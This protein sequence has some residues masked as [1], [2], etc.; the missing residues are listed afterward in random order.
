MKD[1]MP[2]G[3][4]QS[5]S[6]SDL[7]TAAATKT[8]AETGLTAGFS[9]ISDD[10]PEKS[11]AFIDSLNSVLEAAIMQDGALG[12]PD[13]GGNALPLAELAAA[14][15]P[16][17]SLPQTAVEQTQ[18]D[19]LLLSGLPLGTPQA[20]A[21]PVAMSADAAA[22]TD[23]AKLVT[24]TVSQSADT[25]GVDKTLAVDKNLAV[26]S[27]PRT[28][29]PAVTVQTTQTMNKAE[30]PA[31]T[32]LPL[33]RTL[34]AALNPEQ[35]ADATGRG[36]TAKA[37]LMQPISFAE[38]ADGQPASNIDALL[39]ETDRLFTS[40]MQS[41]AV[42]QPTELAAQKLPVEALLNTTPAA[43]TDALQASL[44]RS[45][46]VQAGGSAESVASNGQTAITETFGKADWGQGMGKQIL[47]M[48]NQNISRAEI[49]LN[50]AN[51]GPLEVRIDMDNDQVNVAFTSR[52]ADVREAV[53]LAL[54]RLREMLGDKGLNLADANI[55]Q[56]SFAEQH[57]NAFGQSD[58]DNSGLA[59]GISFGTGDDGLSTDTDTAAKHNTVTQA[60]SESLVDYYI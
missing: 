18:A 56:H 46:M 8:G 40:R 15:I 26:D 29:E 19:T 36:R 24:K 53:E 30:T 43:S 17:E 34:V 38:T 42:N 12:G 5:H 54:P 11:A 44:A 23:P 37:G 22:V 39:S 35:N 58:Q 59:S 27:R 10:L 57:H 14:S 60:L 13:A 7:K 31:L 55:S 47:W 52:H 16:P 4:I 3:L 50:P 1:L 41:L 6:A 51:L 33:A 45:P 28:I 21:E 2:L 48:V 9:G 25:A 20:V 32:L 49:R